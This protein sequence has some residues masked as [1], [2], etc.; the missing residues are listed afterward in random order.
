MRL[1][2]AASCGRD[3]W[4]RRASEVRPPAEAAAGRCTAD[5]PVGGGS[6]W[7]GPRRRR[8]FGELVARAPRRGDCCRALREYMVPRGFLLPATA[9]RS[10]DGGE[11]YGEP[12]GR[13]YWP[14]E[15]SRSGRGAPRRLSA[16]AALA[17]AALPRCTPQKSR[18]G[19]P[20]GPCGVRAQTRHRTH[21]EQSRTHTATHTTLRRVGAPAYRPF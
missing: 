12:R 13:D 4:V 18:R 19:V 5:L 10:H 15:W 8:A 9:R 21:H 6:T 20:H 17:V 1:P 11:S 2:F 7:I 3:A 14:S 16:R